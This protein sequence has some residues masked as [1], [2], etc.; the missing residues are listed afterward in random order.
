MAKWE[1]FFHIRANTS[2]PVVYKYVW[3]REIFPGDHGNASNPVR[4]LI[5]H[6][7]YIFGLKYCVGNMS[8]SRASLLI[9]Q[10]HNAVKHKWYFQVLDSQF[11]LEK[12]EF[13]LQNKWEGLNP[14]QKLHRIR[15]SLYDPEQYQGFSAFGLIDG[16][17]LSVSLIS[18]EY[19]L[20]LGLIWGWALCVPARMQ[21]EQLRWG[22][23]RCCQEKQLSAPVLLSASHSSCFSYQYIFPIFFQFYPVFFLVQSLYVQHPLATSSPVIAFLLGQ[24]IPK[25]WSTSSHPPLTCQSRNWPQEPFYSGWFQI[26]LLPGLT[27]SQKLALGTFWS[28]LHP[29][30]RWEVP[31]G[32][33]PQFQV[34]FIP[35]NL[36]G[37]LPPLSSCCPVWMHFLHPSSSC[38]RNQG[39]SSSSLPF[40]SFTAN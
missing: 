32:K 23:N 24:Q 19:W 39:E 20:W 25:M 3:C 7:G 22:R 10:N 16:C 12:E 26:C 37:V 6:P 9:L 38:C 21:P 36:T 18:W 28:S 27:L 34:Y 29:G 40:C 17:S 33:H 1:F 31:K 30:W 5:T 11:G 8:A 35:W 13:L 2:Q 15:Q 4:S 14:D